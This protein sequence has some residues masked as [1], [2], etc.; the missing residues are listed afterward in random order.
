MTDLQNLRVP[1]NVVVVMYVVHVHVA[2]AYGFLQSELRFDF[3]LAEVPFCA[4]GLL[5]AEWGSHHLSLGQK[6]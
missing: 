1:S 6:H 2:K 4:G 3:V 5:C